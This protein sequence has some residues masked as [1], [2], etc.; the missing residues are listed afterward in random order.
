MVDKLVFVK[1]VL[2]VG[3]DSTKIVFFFNDVPLPLSP[4]NLTIIAC[5]IGD[6]TAENLAPIML[7][8]NNGIKKLKLGVDTKQGFKKFQVYVFFF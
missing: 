5:Y 2:F 4:N 7:N 6:E 1:G 3:G 8:I